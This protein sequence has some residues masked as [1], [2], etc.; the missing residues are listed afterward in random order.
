V[1]CTAASALT[2]SLP[3]CGRN[4][5]SSANIFANAS[6]NLF[7]RQS[8]M[9]RRLPLDSFTSPTELIEVWAGIHTS[10]FESTKALKHPS[11]VLATDTQ[12]RANAW[13]QQWLLAQTTAKW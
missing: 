13:K 7:A 10:S 6:T 5:A 4:C 8:I 1:Y 3:T 12:M 2:R 9:V 11:S